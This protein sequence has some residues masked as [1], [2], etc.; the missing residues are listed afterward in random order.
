MENNRTIGQGFLEK[1]LDRI[2][3][4][5]SF[6]E[7]ILYYMDER[8]EK[9]HV[10]DLAESTGISTRTINKMRSPSESVHH[11]DLKILIA[12]AVGLH[13]MSVHSYYLIHLN[14][15][16]LRKT[17]REEKFYIY[18]LSECNQYSVSEVNQFLI[19]NDLLPLTN[20]DNTD[21]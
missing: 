11:F 18:I 2:G 21:E 12:V 1:D 15:Q 8:G 19:D 13:M 3:E 10:D 6:H 16:T 9:I 20:I 7:L 5:K 4:F 14:G 17:N